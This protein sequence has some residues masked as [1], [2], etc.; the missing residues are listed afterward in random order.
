MK[1]CSLAVAVTLALSLLTSNVHAAEKITKTKPKPAAVTNLETI[2]VTA[3]RYEES[4]QD[5]PIAVSAFN[6]R[7]LFE[8]NVQTLADLQGM[9]PNLQIGP[10]QGTTSTLTVYLR[11]IGQN[12]PLWGFD[13]EVGLYLNGVYIARP[14]GAL[15]DVYDV[16]R[17]EVLRGPQGT[18]YGKNT[19]GGAINFI[20]RPLPIHETGS[21]STTLGMHATRNLKVTYGNA[22][23]D[24]MWRFR[25][26]A[27]SLHNNGFG[28]NLLTGRKTSNT[29]TN[30]ARVSIGFFPNAR[31]NAQFSLD[32]SSDHSNPRGG[33][34]LAVIPFDPM[35]TPP[36][37]NPYNTQSSMPPVNLTDSGGASLIMNWQPSG[38]LTYKSI[39]A[40]RSSNSNMNIDVDTLPLPIADNNLV[41]HSH[42]F[43]QE[44]R[45][46]YDNGTDL[47]GVLGLYFFDGYA[48]GDNKYA[49]LDFPPFTTLGYAL[50]VSSGGSVDTRSLAGYADYTWQFAPRWSL[51]LGARYTH[52]T[53]HAIIRNFTYPDTTF[54]TPNGVQANFSGSTSASNVSPKV[55]LGWK[56]S[57]TVNLYG[58]VSTGFHSG[59]YNIQAN[60]T[61]IPESCRPIRNETLVN[62]ELG[63]KMSFF[64]GRLMLNT[65]AFREIYHN[66]QLSVYTSYVN[67]NGQR[68]FFADFTNAGAAHIDGIENEFSWKMG[69]HWSLNGNLSWLHPRYT[70]YL[71]RGVNI[72]GQS[73]FT[74]APK[75]NGGLTLWKHFPLA[76]GGDVSAHLNVTYQSITYFDQ[77]LSTALAQGGYGLVN[78]GVVWRTGGPWTYSIEGRNLTNKHYRTSGFNIIALGMVT[79]YYAPPRMITAS[80]RYRF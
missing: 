47:H 55:T 66:I 2:M 30:A 11:G 32:G 38:N 26:A 52:D 7:S 51:E 49:L 4:L 6:A 42:Q 18:L 75:W 24:G 43:S 63:A 19:V 74:Y 16:R 64:D 78:A 5:I 13:P 80:A 37:S 15:L 56:A 61:A 70:Q 69:D 65:A 17:I 28:H 20:S 60:C 48:A 71:S 50:R 79:G 36:L 23:S 62:Y 72:A 12:N 9:V 1:R 77:N 67:P 53:K 21:V 59:G 34:R 68:A 44:L 25:A 46:I 10:T 39:T 33:Q 14:Q 35:Q 41:Y 40:Y 54:S 45:A 8:Q 73:R 3:R 76:A 27:V 58:T 22:S 57:D 29:N 31:F